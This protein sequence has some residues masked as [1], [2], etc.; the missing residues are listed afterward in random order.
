MNHE[1]NFKAWWNLPLQL[2]FSK[3]DLNPDEGLSESQII[4]NREKFGRNIL[5]EI[6]QTSIMELIFDGIKQPMM[7][8]LLLIGGISLLFGRPIE[9]FVMMFVVGAYISVEFINKFRTDRT[10]A[11][12]R[13]LAQPTTNVMRNGNKIEIRTSEVVVGDVVILT[14]GVRVPAD[15]RLIESYDLVVN[16]AS[17]TGESFPVKKD[18]QASIKE[19]STLAERK[20]S[21]FSATSVVSGEG[22][23]IVL[24]VGE[25]SEL[26]IIATAVQAQRKEKT[27]MQT[28]MNILAKML[29]IFAIII[30]MIIPAIGFL[31]GLNLQEMILTWLALTFLMIPGQPPIIITM[32]LAL[33]SFALAKKKLV[34]KR[35]RGA[36][37]LGQVTAIMTD[38]TGTITENKMSVRSFIL[39]DGQF[40]KPNKL[41]SEVRNKIS[42]SLPQFS[43][44]PTD[45]AVKTSLGIGKREMAYYSFEGFSENKPWRTLMYK[46]NDSHFFALAGEPESILFN[47]NLTSKEREILLETLKNETKKGYRIIGY[48]YQEREDEI[49]NTLQELEFLALGVIEDPI[50]SGV[51]N[52]VNSLE[53]AG[54]STFIV[55][56]DYPN[57]TAAVAKSIGIESEVVLGKELEK[58]DDEELNV[59]MQFV[60]VFA[61]ISPSQKQRLVT[62]F[63]QRGEI[64]AVIGDGVN[65]APALKAGSVG[66]AMGEIGTDLAKEAADLILTDDNYVHLP[67]AISISRKALDNFSKGLTYY[68]SAKVILLLI[69]L[70]PMILGI[71]FPFA[72]IHIIITELLMDL[73]SSTIFVTESAEANIM[74]RKPSNIKNFLDRNF[75]LR[76]FKNG[77]PFA[78][79][80]LVI[81]LWLY[82]RTNDLILS[83]TA[84]FVT[85]LLG[86]IMLALNLKQEKLPLLKQGI[87]SNR[88][89]SLWLIGMIIF[90]LAITLI[91]FIY[92]YFHTTL[93]PIQVW[94]VILVVIFATTWM[95]E[96][97]KFL[98]KS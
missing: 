22:R 83:Q 64:V 18:A 97:S 19:D 26:G 60:K 4:K 12:L 40:V 13:E 78:V 7:I 41:Q 43:N 73:A 91:P 25:K 35:L 87:F 85:W 46:K 50:R 81:Y 23:G 88:F 89:A 1:N 11:R 15:I 55:T 93:L 70:I 8:V 68:L 52:A 80:I 5:K 84:A 10:M 47:S 82:Y 79:G 3:L 72:P 54:I 21:V 48:A 14:E 66:I 90:T 94:F 96:L 49:N 44:D 98:Y 31:R 16:E 75:I 28:A 65:D 67:E 36:E 9:A 56:G 45:I 20:N 51:K 86:H 74:N 38:K 59:K 61:R 37:I 77:A 69:F 34:V 29:A 62:S 2:I 42:L 57:T 32:A 27:Y 17:L 76:I 39:R 58:M 71:P 53:N 24:V 6:K 95:I 30:S 92:P 33:A 63:T